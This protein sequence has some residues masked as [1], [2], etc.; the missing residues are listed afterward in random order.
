MLRTWTL[1]GLEIGCGYV[2]KVPTAVQLFIPEKKHGLFGCCWYCQW[3]VWII[4][5]IVCSFVNATSTAYLV[6]R[7][8]WAIPWSCLYVLQM[9][10]IQHCIF[11]LK[12]VCLP[13]NFNF[14]AIFLHIRYNWIKSSARPNF[15]LLENWV[16]F[17]DQNI[18]KCKPL[19]PSVL[20]K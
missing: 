2:V 15:V 7:K 20:D 19:L 10:T 17:S 5:H 3:T 14:R 9:I 4:V 1:L 13:E 12:W 6:M 11:A 18:Q 16:N 8:T